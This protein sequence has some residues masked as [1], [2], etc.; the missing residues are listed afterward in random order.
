MSPEENAT[1]HHAASVLSPNTNFVLFNSIMSGFFIFI[2]G[3][4]GPLRD[5]LIWVGNITPVPP[6]KMENAFD[7]CLKTF[8]EMLANL[9]RPL[10]FLFF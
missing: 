4:S 7:S 2:C 5:F 1:I 10:Q 9:S 6:F 8:A 3:F